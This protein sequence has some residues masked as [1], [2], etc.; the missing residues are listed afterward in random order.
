MSGSD[1]VLP[2]PRRRRRPAGRRRT[3]RP[4]LAPSTAGPRAAPAGRSRRTASWSGR[5]ASSR[6]PSTVSRFRHAGGPNRTRPRC[7]SRRMTSGATWRAASGGD[8]T[9]A[10]ERGRR[11]DDADDLCEGG[12]SRRPSPSRL[13]RDA[14]QV[15]GAGGQSSDISGA[16]RVSNRSCRVHARREDPA[17]G[18]PE[19]RSPMFPGAGG[20]R[21]RTGSGPAT[22]SRVAAARTPPC[23]TPTGSRG[24][25]WRRTRGSSASGRCRLLTF[26]VE[27]TVR[28]CVVLSALKASTRS[29]SRR[30]PPN[31]MN[32]L[33]DRS[34]L[35]CGGPTR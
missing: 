11:A 2:A 31:L 19:G 32:L 18:T 34:R 17:P 15:V 13:Q 8:A 21:L 22:G 29:S 1:G 10:D 3:P 25:R 30:P 26:S 27:L 24:C 9:S 12:R 23:R 35:F 7:G 14:G 6:R 20:D 4:R 5:A 28:N 16:I 33:I